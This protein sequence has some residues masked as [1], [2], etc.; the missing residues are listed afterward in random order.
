MVVLT[1]ADQTGW[2]TDGWTSTIS[3]SGDGAWVQT[4][5][6]DIMNHLLLHSAVI[7]STLAGQ[8]HNK[9]ITELIV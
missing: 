7:L 1:G 9:H 6:E 4:K 3:V 2:Q 5:F 8:N